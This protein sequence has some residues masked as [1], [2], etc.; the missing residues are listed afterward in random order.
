MFR[1]NYFEGLQIYQCQ[2]G[3]GSLQKIKWYGGTQMTGTVM[4]KLAD[5]LE[6]VGY[7]IK[8]IEEETYSWTDRPATGEKYTGQI[9][10]KIRSAKEEDA[11][12]EKKRLREE[13]G[14]AA[15]VVVSAL[16]N[17]EVKF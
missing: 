7:V 12:A 4:R 17:E 5:A 13:A 9:C 10:L 16:E 3:C 8:S 14:K 1:G 6:D 11:D 15:P 2:R